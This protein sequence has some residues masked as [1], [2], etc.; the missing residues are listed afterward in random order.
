MTA[1][2]SVLQGRKGA[3]GPPNKLFSDYVINKFTKILHYCFDVYKF[4]V[5]LVS[6]CAGIQKLHLGLNILFFVS[7][8]HCLDHC[9][10]STFVRTDDCTMRYVLVNSGILGRHR[11]LIQGLHAVM[12]LYSSH[13]LPPP[14]SPQSQSPHQLNLGLKQMDS[15]AFLIRSNLITTCTS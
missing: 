11:C 14:F 12:M 10:I 4:I 8:S 9:R 3:H 5:I 2:K 1:G 13:I 7:T 15:W 6:N